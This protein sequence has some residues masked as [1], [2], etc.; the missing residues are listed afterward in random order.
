MA[1]QQDNPHLTITLTGRP[2]VKIVKG[3]WPVL[4]M[5]SDEWWEGQVKAQAFRRWEAKITVRQHADGRAIVYGMFSYYTAW[6]K[7]HSESLRA[8]ELLDRGASIPEAIQRVGR[9]IEAR[10]HY[11]DA[12]DIFSS[13][14]IHECIAD[15]P[16]VEI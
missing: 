3:D 1:A 15:L 12:A 10:I 8:G 7:E 13:R 6:E 2:P 4:A 14:L 9:E 5:A 16:A 11:E